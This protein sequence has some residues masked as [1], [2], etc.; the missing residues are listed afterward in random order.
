MPESGMTV[1]LTIPLDE[2]TDEELAIGRLWGDRTVRDHFHMEDNP[3]LSS[4]VVTL[5]DRE[6][7]QVVI[8]ELTYEGSH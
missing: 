4:V 7:E 6:D 1:K 8:Y 5:A 3:T 2:H